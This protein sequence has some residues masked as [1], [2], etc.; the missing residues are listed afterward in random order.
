MHRSG[1]ASKLPKFGN[2]LGKFENDPGAVGCGSARR[3]T[4]VHDPRI[5][6]KRYARAA[7]TA[8]V[9]AHDVA[10]FSDANIPVTVGKRCV[11]LIDEAVVSH[12][13]NVSNLVRQR[14]SDC[15]ARMMHYKV[16]IVRVGTNTCSQTTTSGVV[17]DQTHDIGALLIAQLS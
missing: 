11:A 3:L 9:I 16:R 4:F 12:A 13:K 15:C 14:K 6:P 2:A 17:N 7:A 5:R 10:P 1:A 8:F